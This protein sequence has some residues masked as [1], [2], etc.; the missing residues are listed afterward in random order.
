MRLAAVVLLAATCVAAQDAAAQGAEALGGVVVEAGSAAPVPGAELHLVEAGIATV[1]DSA[2][3][4]RF[5]SVPAGTHTLRV[6]RIG[7]APR[8]VTVGA[9]RREGTLVVEL[10]P[11]ALALD[12]IVVTGSR[13]EQRLA[14]VA[15]PTEI[16]SRETIEATGAAD[17]AAVLTEQTG[18]QFEAGMPSGAGIMLQGLSSERVLVLVDGR[19][20]AGRIAGNFDLAR[21]PS[22]IVERIEVVKG[23]Q[24]ALY[25]SEAMGGVVNVI[26][27]R[28][29]AAELGGAARITAGS[30]G[31]FDAGVTGNVAAGDF[32]GVIDVGRRTVDLAPG[33]AAAD[34]ALSERLDV[35]A[36]A[37]WAPA[38]SWEVDAALLVLD[39][40]QRWP[41]GGAM[42][43]FADNAVIDASLGATFT[44]GMHRLRPAV[45][46]SHFD[47]LAR[48][49]S[50]A[51]PIA[52]T[53]DRQT[54]QL[55]EAEL[56][57]SGPLAGLMVDG[58]VEVKE[59]R[60]TST[61]GRI[62]D[63]ARTLLS[64]EPFVQADWSSDRVSI[65]PGARLSWNERWGT[66]LTPRI[67][68]RYRLRDDLSIRAAAGRGFRSPDFK[69]LY[70]Q[71]QND[72][73]SPPYAVYGNPD[74]RPEHSTNLTTAVEWTGVTVYARAQGFWNELHDFIE[75]RPVAG[76]G[77]VAQYRY[78]NV[79]RG[80]TWGAEAEAGLV[81]APVRIETGYAWLGTEDRD[82][83]E[84]LL[85]R[86][87]HS[88]RLSVGF[89]P[90]PKFRTTITA[91]HTGATPMERAGDGTITSEREAWSR[92]DV[93][94]AR[95]LPAGLE[96]VL[97]ADNVFDSR[98]DRW[99]DAVGRRWYA[100]LRWNTSTFTGN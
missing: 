52:G 77:G 33:R 54:Q 37:G 58:G 18:I 56:L 55:L 79:S 93:R 2:G 29:A 10:E 99:A 94:L 71:F 78:G 67:A 42:N 72:A 84:P 12:Q 57:Y 46:L 81:L 92:L 7:F 39:E 73:A 83:G 76:G 51:Q 24:S 31:R 23:P 69:E 97:G 74:L 53:G 4:W 68:V 35:S 20:L 19:P 28:P 8:L 17:L 66:T 34:G 21:I 16:V 63:G 30:E 96:A 95:Q 87:E 75:T 38:G 70:L 36:R 15:V 45:H 80:R 40:R 50:L 47:H 62:G 89:A 59:E 5:G 88:A 22:D 27:R 44:A 65:V 60:I 90:T 61:D 1:A 100:G 13:R 25:G 48:R 6:R 9:P 41:S 3:R 49:S 11:T 82:T 91:V 86:P 43:D 64:A 32:A 85:G 26:T 98:P 14:D